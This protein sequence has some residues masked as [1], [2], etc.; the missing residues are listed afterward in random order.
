MVQDLENVILNSVINERENKRMIILL[1][2]G[3]LLIP[4]VKELKKQGGWFA[5]IFAII[6]FVVA[7]I[8]GRATGV[9]I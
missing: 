6:A 1:V 5:V 9:L 4:I 3:V 7:G 8:I 2:L